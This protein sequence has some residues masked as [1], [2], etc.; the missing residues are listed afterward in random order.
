[1]YKIFS[2]YHG[3]ENDV[4]RHAAGPIHKTN[5]IRKNTNKLMTDFVMT[6]LDPNTDKVTAAECTTGYHTVQREHSYRSADCDTK[7]C[8][9]FPDSD[10]VKKLSCGRTKAEAIVTGVLD[11]ASVDDSLGILHR[12]M[13][14]IQEEYLTPYLSTSSNVSNH[15]SPKMFPAAT[16]FWTHKRMLDFYSDSEE[17]AGI[18][19]NQLTSRLK[20]WIFHI[21]N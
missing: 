3:G 16:K 15:G 4:T 19:A 6:K 10:I 5:V 1:L 13:A 8:Q 21:L 7:L 20:K 9:T 17:S 12:N 18:I 14:E 11:A 2:I